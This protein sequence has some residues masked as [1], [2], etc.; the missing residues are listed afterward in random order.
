MN[1]I[2]LLSLLGFFLFSIAV[3]SQTLPQDLELTCATGYT[4]TGVFEDG[5]E[6]L[7]GD[8]IK[9][10]GWSGDISQKN[11]PYRPGNGKWGISYGAHPN[12]S[13]KE[14]ATSGTGP[15]ESYD[16]NYFLMFEANGGNNI[17]EI[18]SPSVDLS[19]GAFVDSDALLEFKMFAFGRDMGKLEVFASNN[20]NS[21]TGD[22]LFVHEGAYQQ[23]STVASDPWVNVR[24][25]LK[26]FVGGSVFIKLK[27]TALEAG[28][29]NLGDMCIDGLKVLACVDT[30]VCLA[31]PVSFENET[32]S[33]VDVTYYP[34]VGETKWE[35]FHQKSGLPAP[36]ESDSGVV[37]DG[38]NDVTIQNLDHTTSY[39]VY[40][41]SYCESAGTVSDW[42]SPQSFTTPIS[43]TNTLTCGEDY[44][45]SFC[46]S[47]INTDEAKTETY[48]YVSSD[49]ANGGAIS[50]FINDGRLADKSF[51][52]NDPALVVTDGNGTVL[53]NGNGVRERKYFSLKGM[54]FYSATGS[55]TFQLENLALDASCANND[56]FDQLKPIDYTV[57]CLS[58]D[59]PPVVDYNLSF[60]EDCA[61]SNEYY[62]DVEVKNMNGASNI[63]FTNDFNDVSKEANSLGVT[64]VGPFPFNEEVQVYVASNSVDSG[65]ITQR[66]FNIDT[67]PPS[68]DDIENAIEL[69]ISP[70]GSTPSEIDWK[71][72]SLE[73]A[74]A[75]EGPSIPEPSCNAVGATNDIWFKVTAQQ[76]LYTFAPY[77][78]QSQKD[79]M[80]G[81]SKDYI[82]HV[83]YE[84]LPDGSL[85]ELFCYQSF[86]DYANTTPS[87]VTPVLTIGNEYYFRVFSQS[88]DFTDVDMRFTLFDAT[89][90]LPGTCNGGESLCFDA[91]GVAYS[92]PMINFPNR[93]VPNTSCSLEWMMNTKWP[94]FEV[95]EDG[96]LEFD[97]E[98]VNVATDPID[99]ALYGPFTDQDE[100]CSEIYQHRAID[101]SDGGAAVEKLS[102]PNAKKGEKYAFLIVNRSGESELLKFTQTNIDEDGAATLAG[103]SPTIPQISPDPVCSSNSTEMVTLSDYDA[104]LKN[105]VDS[106]AVSYYAT[107]ALETEI[108]E[109]QVN[110]GIATKV[111]AQVMSESGCISFTSFD[112]NMTKTPVVNSVIPTIDC[113]VMSFDLTS[114]IDEITGGEAG[115]EVQFFA[116]QDAADLG[117]NPINT[118]L[119]NEGVSTQ[120]FVRVQFSQYNY[121]YATSAITLD[122]KEAPFAEL[123]ADKEVF[124]ACEAEPLTLSLENAN[125]EATAV[126]ITWYKDGSI[127]ENEDSASLIV[128]SFG[129]YKAKVTSNESACEFETEQELVSLKDCAAPIGPT[130]PG[131]LQVT[132]VTDISATASWTAST[133]EDG[134]TEYKLYLND[135]LLS[136][137]TE[138]TYALEGLSANTA[139]TFKVVPYDVNGTVGTSSQVIFITESAD[140]GDGDGSLPSGVTNPN[141]NNDKIVSKIVSLNNP[142]TIDA[143]G[144]SLTIFNRNG[145]TIISR[146]NYNNDWDASDL[147]SGTYFYVITYSDNT[148]KAGTI[149]I[150]K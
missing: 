57:K 118:N 140:N 25:S 80:Y 18:L 135:E 92:T 55:I 81:S 30:T 68:N 12:T 77:V 147:S 109:I 133:D 124:E 138:L 52:D 69:S 2:S 39:D 103:F 36:Q 95:A 72:A 38:V 150:K 108:T 53:Y 45:T 100:Y 5:F 17:A 98:M 91:E 56:I 66:M 29:A 146:S 34:R 6:Y 141:Y 97:L 134:V 144:V 59:T 19:S 130:A 84:K 107:E 63:F 28:T 142:L 42:S 104:S 105:G 22:A 128:T 21:F 10:A 33:S 40:L 115:L 131:D 65:C 113:S 149:F 67:C 15:D 23:K 41:R 73:H 76:P 61:T 1:K 58:C 49:A 102:V 83:M 123:T 85:K 54:S 7:S 32:I 117:E 48:T 96:V 51:S 11:S 112:L 139:Y 8:A 44:R 26:D 35:Y 86:S 110:E 99:V 71:Y 116:T 93:L 127:I 132:E 120:V 101:C 129:Y 122:F 16:G 114:L 27:Y 74:T 148:T 87:T 4:E 24:V 3:N 20:K 60:P 78:R 90:K 143:N 46:Y 13:Y 43:Y 121:C 9:A 106:Y 79:G 89:S 136:T 88:D 62:V 75:S 119:T 50:L 70:Y 125:F 37:L 126:G 47:T 111:Y 145:Q 31:G 64:R 137:L 14:S 94:T 82:D